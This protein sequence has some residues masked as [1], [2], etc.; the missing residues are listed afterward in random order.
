MALAGALSL[1]AVEAGLLAAAGADATGAMAEARRG[2]ERVGLPHRR[3]E[4]FRWSDF[5]AALFAPTA[6]ALRP[7]TFP[8]TPPS[9]LPAFAGAPPFALGAYEIEIANGVAEEAAFAPEGVEVRTTLND[10]ALP[11]ALSAHPL[12]L[13]S[14]STAARRTDV[15]ATGAVAEPVWIRRMAGE[16]ASASRV[17]IVLEPGAALTVIESFEGRRGAFSA[18]VTEFELGDGAAL[19]RFILQEADADAVVAAVSA[20]RLGKAARFEQTALAFGARL[21]RLETRLRLAGDATRVALRSA[22]LVDDARH[23]DVTSHVAHEA[24]GG[25][26]RQIH[27]AV[28]RERGRGVFQGK[29]LVARGAQ[30]TDA[31]MQSKALLLSDGAE[32]DHKPELEIYADDVQCAHGATTGALD[33]DALFYLRQRGLPEIAARAL[34]VEAFLGEVFDAVAH[35][36]VA[37]TFRTRAAR[38]MEAA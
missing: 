37:A 32:A 35:T 2:F 16:G 14:A 34:L 38:W 25:E 36:G 15:V 9:L 12:A 20:A 13:L 6:P 33:A 17:R 10:R 7:D 19:T 5:R 22:S 21:A 3:V 23:A 18:D 30:K 29:F 11:E 4:A 1:S 31:A 26:T 8:S 24:V 28:L 27:K